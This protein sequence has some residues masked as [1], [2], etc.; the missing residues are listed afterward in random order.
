MPEVTASS[1]G[2][3]P[4]TKEPQ[5]LDKCS[6]VLGEGRNGTVWKAQSGRSTNSRED[7]TTGIHKKL[8]PRRVA[9]PSGVEEFP[10]SWRCFGY[11]LQ[12]KPNTG[13]DHSMLGSAKTKESE[14]S[15]L[16]DKVAK[17]PGL[18]QMA[19]GLL[20]E[21][22]KGRGSSRGDS[23]IGGESGIRSRQDTPCEPSL[24]KGPGHRGARNKSSGVGP[25][26]LRPLEAEIGVAHRGIGILV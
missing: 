19:S 12:D 9:V 23:D 7:L 26:S 13:D 24:F 21:A 6:P 1:L 11:E 22:C 3:T 16:S 25:R 15:G 14:Q 5:S 18:Q 4:S 20:K 2:G 10:N 17:V 8:A